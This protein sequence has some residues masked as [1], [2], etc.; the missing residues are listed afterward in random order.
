MLNKHGLAPSLLELEVTET[1]LIRDLA[2]SHT[3]LQTLRERGI[4]IALDDFGTGYSSLAYL[5][6]LPLDAVKNG[7]TSAVIVD[8]R[9][10]HAILLEIFTNSGVGTLITDKT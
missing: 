6:S 5:A 4:A 1:Q 2:L 8:G 3:I 10:A 7:V 9:V